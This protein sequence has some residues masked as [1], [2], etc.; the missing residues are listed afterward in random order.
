MFYVYIRIFDVTDTVEFFLGNINKQSHHSRLEVR[1]GRGSNPSILCRDNENFGAISKLLFYRQLPDQ[2]HAS[3]HRSQLA[4]QP[5]VFSK[6]FVAQLVQ[7]NYCIDEDD[8]GVKMTRDGY[9]LRKLLGLQIYN[10]TTYT[11]E[12]IP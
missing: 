8:E 10:K 4:T 7:S 12:G 11:D 9:Y 6:M 5:P 3:G 2:P 1:V